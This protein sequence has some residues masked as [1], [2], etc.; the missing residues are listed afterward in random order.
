V[1]RIG[2]KQGIFRPC[3]KRGREM[4]KR[5]ILNKKKMK[6]F[7]MVQ[8]A[9]VKISAIWAGMRRNAPILM[10]KFRRFCFST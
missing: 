10:D 9:G 2:L 1:A 5:L 4:A 6:T 3:E 8:I 7:L